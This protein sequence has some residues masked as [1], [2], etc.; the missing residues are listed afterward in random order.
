MSIRGTVRP[1]P[2]DGTRLGLLRS[3]LEN[4]NDSVLV[5]E[6]GPLDEPG[7]R[8][9]YANP[10]FSRTTGYS[11]DEIVGKTPRALHG[12]ETDRA[13][14]DEIRGALE[15]GRSV[16]TELLN[17]RKDGTPFWVELDIV[18]VFDEGS[19]WPELWVS[20]QRE[21]TER[22]HAERERLEAERRLRSVLARYGS[23]MITIL[24][25]DG[26]PRY[27]SPAVQRA[28]GYRHKELATGDV[29]RFVHP[30]DVEVLSRSVAGSLSTPG[31]SPPVEFRMRHADG[32][33]RW[34]ESVGKNLSHDPDVGGIVVVT[35]EVTKRREAEEALKQ[36]E[37]LLRAV[38]TGASVV[39]FAADLEGKIT[40][41]EGR[42]LES[43]GEGPGE[44]VG[45]SI[46]E[47]CA[48]EPDVLENVERALAGEEVA[49]TV[50]VGGLAFETRYS[51]M[52]DEDGA[53]TGIV[54]VATDV[55]ER[56]RL[57][58]ELEHRAFHDS[59]TGLPNRDLLADRLG[60]ALG[61]TQRR[62][63]RVAVL[64]LDL[65]NFKVVNDSLGH[66]A[67]DELLVEVASRIRSVLRPEDTVSR[68][69]G[70]EFVV[71][72][73]NV[74]GETEA[75]EVAERVIR[76]LKPPILLGDEEVFVTAS[77]GV[78]LGTS[79]GGTTPEALLADADAAMY[80]AKAKGRNGYELFRPE[81]RA[82]PARRLRLESDLRRAL[83]RGELTLFYQPQAL[84][85]TGEIVGTEA[86][87]RWMHPERGLVGPAEFIGLAEE[88][89]LIVSIGQWVL[90]EACRQ[91]KAW[92]VEGPA[93]PSQTMS[94]NLSARQF[95]DP[96]LV[97][98]VAQALRATGLEPSRLTLEITEG[99]LMED[100]PST[101][102]ARRG[103]KAL[104]G[105]LAIDDF[106][107]G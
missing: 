17:Y 35:R 74:T 54:G 29:L 46:R 90:E 57:E 106:G 26:T 12:P 93:G 95:D 96:D 40:L 43:V 48:D 21:T 81:M 86:L 68:L 94:V 51:P 100:V 58:K 3:I 23:D 6:G 20:V 73:E 13:R 53:V 64:F 24:E 77:I 75:T 38:V 61:R 34:F 11:R 7:P 105:G 84:V 88:T 2:G 45:R 25:P 47:I 92:Q 52:L 33:W 30:D 56:R 89:G 50:E 5:T 8:I 85:E 102:A 72:L 14:L 32:S 104:G 71:L 41:S 103:L 79:V 107:T 18:P 39:V 10:A 9:V 98:H 63:D 16:R 91:A 97:G 49:A 44:A 15:A 28:L 82:A 69:G 65:D 101:F 55:S 66:D 1:E 36:S 59:L 70:D 80:R 19:G 27:E 67:G 62:W 42:A 60:H 87:L 37:K 99:A 4:A 31:E 76:A 78:A 83:E 22:V